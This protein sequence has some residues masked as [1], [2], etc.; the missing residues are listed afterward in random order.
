MDWV[1]EVVVRLKPSVL[2]PQGKTVQ[3]ALASL[4]FD[5]VAAV[6]MGKA[7]HL[8]L[9]APDRPRAEA[10]VRAM[11]ERLLAN[12]IIETFQ[13]ELKEVPREASKMTRTG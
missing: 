2:D 7:I 5:E 9:S 6:R 4:G 10:R 12:P 11:C 13:F 3:Q 8:Q 1:A